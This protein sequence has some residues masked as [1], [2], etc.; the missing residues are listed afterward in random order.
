MAGAPEFPSV[1]NIQ[2][3]Y[4]WFNPAKNRPWANALASDPSRYTVSV[5]MAQRRGRLFIDYLRN[6][7]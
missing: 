2:G 4:N 5:S 3:Y 7:G 6:G 1:V